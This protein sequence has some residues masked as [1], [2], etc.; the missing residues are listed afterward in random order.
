LNF[1]L[2]K[3]EWRGNWEYV[4]HTQQAGEY[5]MI[6]NKKFGCRT[7]TRSPRILWPG[8]ED[9]Q[10]PRNDGD[11]EIYISFSSIASETASASLFFFACAMCHFILGCEGMRS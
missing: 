4:Y 7:R 10:E 2:L 1:S 6:T 9:E 3:L 8:G 11:N 5:N